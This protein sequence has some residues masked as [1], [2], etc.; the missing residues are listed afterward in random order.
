ME[1]TLLTGE[2]KIMQFY[3][4]SLA[5]TYQKVCGGVVFSQQELEMV[6]NSTEDVILT[7]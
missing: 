1:Y 6:D 7:P 2:G 4:R 5:E 3:L